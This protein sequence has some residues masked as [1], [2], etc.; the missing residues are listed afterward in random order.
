MLLITVILS[1]R[2][3][4][5]RQCPVWNLEASPLPGYRRKVST[6][7]H[8]RNRGLHPVSAWENS[9]PRCFLQ[10]AATNQG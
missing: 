8:R 5:L 1:H 3:R 7:Q 6:Y 4:S 9:P 10:R 2:R